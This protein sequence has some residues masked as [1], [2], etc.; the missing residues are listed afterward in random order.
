M[1]AE[2]SITTIEGVV[3]RVHGNGFR[4]AGREGF[5]NLSKFAIPAP[6]MPTEGQRVAVGID[7]GGFV[8]EVIVARDLAGGQDLPP[9]DARVIGTDGTTPADRETRIT[10]MACLNTATAIL[11]TRNARGGVDVAEVLSVAAE[12]ERWV[13][14]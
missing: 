9:A 5:L 6:A 1:V 3:E 13:L 11:T 2:R 12:L 10:R 14:R 4:L 8:R 7:K